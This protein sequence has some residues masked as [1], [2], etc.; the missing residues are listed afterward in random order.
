M[1]NI[2]ELVVV[3]VKYLLIKETR[4]AMN[5]QEPQPIVSNGSHCCNF[6]TE[7][8][9]GMRVFPFGKDIPN[10]G[11]VSRATIWEWGSIETNLLETAQL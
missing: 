1:R 10:P 8:L 6:E 9:R 7:S 4:R 11:F 5:L 3:V 2:R